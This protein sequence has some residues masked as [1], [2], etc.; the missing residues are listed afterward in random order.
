MKV[1]LIIPTL[2]EEKRIRKLLIYLQ[3]LP[4]QELLKEIIV[5]D[6]GSEDRT[7]EEAKIAGVQVLRSPARGRA[8]QMNYAAAQSKGAI[9]YFVHADVFPPSSCL[10]DIIEALKKG[11]HMGCFQCNFTDESKLLQ[12]N[13]RLTKLNWMAA[14]GGDQT[15][16]IQRQAFEQLNGFDESLPIMEDFDIVWRAKKDY[17]F[18]VIKSKALVSAR[19]YRNNSYL[20]VQLTN[21]VVFLLFRWG[22]SPGKLSRMYKKILNP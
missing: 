3:E 20:K 13:S 7:L 2:N 15:F 12:F 16:F 6:G 10:T 21:A 1:S 14:G 11:P 8:I 18:H 5:C 22:A 4:H 19:K 9:L 17:Y